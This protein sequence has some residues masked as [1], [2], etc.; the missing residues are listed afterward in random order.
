[1]KIIDFRFINSSDA[2][3]DT[4]P[5]WSRKFEYPVILDILKKLDLPKT[6][7][8]HN[9]SWGFDIEHHQK[10]K[11]Q[12]ELEYGF[13]HVINSD[14]LY[15]GIPNTYVHDITQ[16]PDDDFK[17]QFDVVLNV[18]ALEEIPG[19]HVRYLNNLLS[20]VR[21]GG[22]LII[23]FD[24]PGLQL[25][26]IQE[27]VGSEISHEHYHNRIIGSGAPWFDGL[28]VGLLVVQK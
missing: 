21:S 7:K 13:H 5:H 24:L 19:D 9:S 28:N 26:K 27:F 6:P 25:D 4:Y 3:D 18:S 15:R 16:E 8:I 22:Y 10:F 17:H 2:F 12:L 23:T 20:Q 11:E 14:I 1:M